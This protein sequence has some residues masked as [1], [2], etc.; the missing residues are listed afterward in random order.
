VS[1]SEAIIA[2]VHEPDESPRFAYLL[3]LHGYRR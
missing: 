3:S 1:Q 2:E